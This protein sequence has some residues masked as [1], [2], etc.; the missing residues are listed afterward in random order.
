MSDY[1]SQNSEP[2]GA[3]R[4]LCFPRRSLA[5]AALFVVAFG[6]GLSGV[7]KDPSVDAFVPGDHPAA[8]ARDAARSLFGL[9]D[10]LVIGLTAPQGQSAFTVQGL[11]ALRRVETAV[12]EVSG[13]KRADVVSLATENAIS[14]NDG[15]LVVEPILPEGAVSE[16]SARLALARYE[17]MPMLSGLL[18][19]RAGDMLVII[20]PVEDP[21]HAGETVRMVIEKARAASGVLQVH[22]AGVAAMNARLAEMVDTDT[23]I[24]VPAAIVVVLLLLFV[25]MR[26]GKAVVGP[27][28]VIAGSAA[29]AIGLMGWMDARY[30]LITTALPVVIMAIAVADT[31]HIATFYLKARRSTDANA[32][33]AVQQALHKTWLPITLTTITTIAAFIGL[34]FGAAMTPISE[35]GAFAAVGVAAAW[36]LSL[37]ALPA[38]LILLDVKPRAQTTR[39]PSPE[40]VNRVVV[41]FSDFALVNPRVAI[42]A[43]VAFV[44][45][46]AA[47]ATQ[48]TFNYE[49]ERYFTPGDSVRVADSVINTQLGGINFLDVIV[50]APEPGGLMRPEAM[51]AIAELRAS[52]ATLPHVVKVSGIDEYISLMHSVLQGAPAGTLPTHKR[53]PGQY[54]FLYEAA[55]APGDFK[56]EIDYP[57]SNALLRAQMST[58]RFSDAA[59]TMAALEAML[60]TWSSSHNLDAKVSGRVAVNDGWMSQLANNHFRGLGMATLLVFLT[61]LAVFR[62]PAYA[63]L[64]MMPLMV[65]V[66]A[67]YASMGAFGIDIAPATSMTAAIATGLGVDF[68]IHLISHL[69]KQLS[70]GASLTAALQGDYVLVARACFYSAVALGIALAVICISSA[71]PLRWFGF[72]V[73]VGAFGS[74]VGALV[75]VPGVLAI[76]TLFTSRRLQHA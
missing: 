53:A 64:A 51:S 75:I 32:T 41:R 25:A 26:T 35:F 52:M 24:F 56:Q 44:A 33:S 72:L 22:V 15:D 39:E 5:L 47:F 8:L 11:E 21:N 48:A 17:S 29:V 60:S 16:A 3:W 63:A 28:F 36:V 30:Y 74:L 68:G 76:T 49:R 37:L 6:A 31:L 69:R 27:L 18:A 4:Y 50:S 12:K 58:D 20:A 13:I 65:G 59:P 70:A 55:G 2:Q 7:R 1:S 43:T 10:P 23:R 57:Y 71:P 46:L 9:E 14:S 19:S 66:L 34:S 40:L 54:M 67:V 61:A 38:I 62:S 73:S 45:L 42:G